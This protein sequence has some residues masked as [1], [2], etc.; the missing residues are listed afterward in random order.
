VKGTLR[1]SLLSYVS[2][3]TGKLLTL[4]ST[5]VLARVLDPSDF[6]LVGYALL[7]LSF[8]TVLKSVGMGRAL[9]YRQDLGEDEA[10]EVFVISFLFATL[11]TG[12][13]WLT[14]P[15]VA[16]FFGEPRMTIVARVLS[17]S[18]ILNAL[19]EAHE[20]QLKKRMQFGRAFTP[21]IVFS[22]VRGV[23]SVALALLGVGYWSLVWGQLSGDAAHTLTC[24]GLFRWRPRVR[25]SRAT[26][27]TILRF[28]LSVTL[29]ELI[30]LVV[31]NA[32]EV[33]VGRQLG[34]A[35]L[36]LYSIGYTLAQFV[37]ISL[38]SAV[39][40]A[41]FPAFAVV[42]SDATALRAGYLDVLR[43]SS[44]VLAPAGAGL[45]VTAPT[46]VHAFF[47]SSWWPMIAV[48]QA[49]ALYGAIFAIGW[50]AGDV[51]LALG[52]PDLQWKLDAGQVVVLVPALLAGAAIDGI[53]GVAIAQVVAIVPY[54]VA[55]FWLIHETLGVHYSEI[56]AR[57]RLPLAAAVALVAACAVVATAGS[58][59]PAG[60]TL[61]LQVVVG[62]LVYCGALL[63]FDGELRAH[64]FARFRYA[65]ATS[66]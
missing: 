39:S 57:L 60:A 54:S 4:G 31:I 61:A 3:L 41:V 10:G 11:F 45:F 26:G 35:A 42:Q 53:T 38:A 15:L 16:D 51:W 2:F 8:L 32:D 1:G 55:R 56:A 12:A 5:L 24:W 19:G 27:L 6:G 66:R 22:I 46:L 23:V 40:V 7:M 48:V 18:F 30:S 20:T 33:I 52:R 43:W 13:A 62:G 17:L 49:L 63:R 44:L 9:I 36:G 14:A 50:S 28:G 29:L 65:E 59:L 25:L 21:A 34:R 64:A 37:T 58:S 47:T